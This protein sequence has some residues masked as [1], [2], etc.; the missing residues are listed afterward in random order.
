MNSIEVFASNA[1][2]TTSQSANDKCLC[3][4]YV[5]NTDKDCRNVLNDKC[6]SD[7]VVGTDT[8]FRT[9][10]EKLIDDCEKDNAVIVFISSCLF[11]CLF[12]I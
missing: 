2:F 9:I 12:E 10:L 6:F 5:T 11:N 3:G 8:R 4:T 7:V 1:Y